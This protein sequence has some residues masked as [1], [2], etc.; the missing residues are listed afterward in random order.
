[1]QKTILVTGANG[2]LGR[3]VKKAYAGQDVTLIETEAPAVAGK[4][5][6]RA[7][8]ITDAGQVAAAVADAKADVIINCAA[9][10]AVDKQEEDSDLSYLIN[11]IGP[12]NLAM[13]AERHGAQLI[14]V[15][16]DYVFDGR[17]SR[18]Y[19]EWDPTSPQSVYGRS[20][21]AGEQ[22]VQMFCGRFAILRT[23][24]L[25]GDGNNFARTMLRLSG[26]HDTVSV[27]DDQT[28]TPT[29]ADALSLAV[30]ALAFTDNYGIFH[31]TCE[32]SCSW[33]DFAEEVFRLAGK[34][35][36]VERV[37]TAEYTK[38]NPQSAPRPMYSILD[39]M[40]LRLTGACTFPDWH[41]ALED[42]MRQMI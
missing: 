2:Q 19:T 4:T 11:A 42:Y 41:E 29:S 33:A 31:A 10:T 28:G 38:K 14:H 35:T 24:W 20:K 8:D 26:T 34:D 36:R 9:Y 16:T 37:S 40:M 21:L 23:A 3:A 6:H 5:G 17:A 15:S 25:Y 1:M 13:A 39:N 7:L 32:G 12:R 27:V 30:R 18:P 22:M